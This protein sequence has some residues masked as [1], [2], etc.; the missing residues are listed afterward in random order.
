MIQIPGVYDDVAQPAPEEKES[1]ERLPFEEAEFLAEEVGATALTGEPGYSVLE[2][3]WSRPTFEVH[4]IAGGF[5][6]AG[7]KTVIPATATAKV[8]MRLVPKQD[9]EKVVAAVRA[10][11]E[12]QRAEGHHDR[13][14]RAERGAGDLGGSRTIRR[15]KWR[16]KPSA[17]CWANRRCSFAAAGRFRWWAISRSIWASQRF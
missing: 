10:F 13:S 6:G 5:T 3:V 15:F 17:T 14:A 12:E 9:P 2:R 16:R 1:W 11:L 4:G 7:A 8:S